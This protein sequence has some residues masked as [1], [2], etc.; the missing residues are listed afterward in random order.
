MS[1]A[2]NDPVP[3]LRQLRTVRSIERNGSLSG[4]AR[5]LNRTQS[6]I[7]K[8]LSEMEAR[9]GIRLFDRFAHGVAPTAHGKLLIDRIREAEL[10]FERAA[11]AHKTALRRQPRIQKNPVFTMEISAKRLAAFIAVRETGDVRQAA[12]VAGVTVS[13]VYDSLRTLEELLELP[14]FESAAAGLRSTPF[15][16]ILA[17]H[18]QLALSLLR[19]GIDEIRSI[20]GTIRGQ[21]IIGTL[22]YSR[23]VIV[24]R[25]IHR[26]LL[27]HG[28]IAIRTREG[29][30]DVL[31][32]APSTS[33][34]AQRVNCRQIRRCIPKTCS[35]MNWP[36]LA[37]QVT[38]L[39]PAN[40]CQL[41]RYSTTAGYYRRDQHR[42]D[43]C[44]TGFSLS[45]VQ[46][47]R[48]R[49]SRRVPCLRPADYFW[50]VTASLCCQRTRSN[51]IRPLVY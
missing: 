41:R 46:K 47:S 8:A 34:L 45:G 38:R 24:P 3:S 23:T 50:K 48:R 22:P 12:A 39:R 19:H 18:A 35:R 7:S 27:A 33:S 28:E 26:V 21:L 6:A 15:A 20:D 17:S 13:A 42:H 36:S 1:F 37:E 25:A 4:A 31:E 5:E 40:G 51:S 32:A 11:R 49:L 10:Q 2:D 9:L 29:P 16:D 43:S 30:Y 44:S 14:L